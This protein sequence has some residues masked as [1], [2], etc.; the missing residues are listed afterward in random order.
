MT[1]KPQFE[2]KKSGLCEGVLWLEGALRRYPVTLYNSGVG[3]DHIRI[4][5]MGIPQ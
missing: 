1:A 3:S 5:Q 2:H 4:R